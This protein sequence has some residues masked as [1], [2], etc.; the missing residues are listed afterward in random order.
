MAKKP[1][2]AILDDIRARDER[3][4]LLGIGPVS[5]NVI[6]ASF[7]SAARHHYPPMFI[8]SRNQVDADE[9]GG[10]Y[11]MGWDQQRCM[12]H[13]TEAAKQEN[14]DGP[15]YM[16]RDH[17]G[18]WQRDE[19]YKKKIPL[20]KA[21]ALGLKSFEADIDNGFDLLHIDPTK[22]PHQAGQSNMD[23]ILKLTIDLISQLEAYRKDRG[24]PEI[25]Y[26]IGTEE[27]DGGLTS[28]GA[29]EHFIRKYMAAAEEKGLPKPAFVV[30]QTG[31]LTRL[32]ENVGD[33]DK[34]AAEKLA[35]V[36]DKYGTGLKEHNCDYLSEELLCLHTGLG[37]HGANVAPEFGAVE[38]AA[39]LKLAAVEARLAAQRGFAASN[40]AQVLVQNAIDSGKWKKWLTADL[41]DMGDNISGE[42]AILI[43]K[44]SG[45][46]TLASP[47]FLAE[48][49][50]MYANLAGAGIDGD[51]Y[52]VES[53]RACIDRYVRNFNL[54]HTL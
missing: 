53:V 42:N 8:A 20:A 36:C 23:D 37:I 27:T 9:F 16:C 47:D 30:G 49:A 2:S 39:Y 38:S 31:T 29:F 54:Y 3:K 43:T 6:R 34:T 13:M 18:P 1:I 12:A 25:S 14:F 11:V 32:I 44:I 4:T 17:G 35:A 46:Y 40:T 50:N 15:F 24:G 28:I 33:F 51:E 5:E 52:V 41:T 10:G 26:E 45:H 22:N 21:L 7:R 48:R 19:E